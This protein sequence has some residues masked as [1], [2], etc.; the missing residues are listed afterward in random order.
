LCGGSGSHKKNIFYQI[1]EGTKGNLKKNMI[2]ENVYIKIVYF[3]FIFSIKQPKK[4]HFIIFF[5]Y[6]IYFHYLS[7]NLKNPYT[8]I[9]SLLKKNLFNWMEMTKQYREDQIKKT[10]RKINNHIE[11]NSYV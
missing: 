9:F 1:G 10:K 5:I 3:L 2:F 8:Y 4:S 11:N 7:N 6:F